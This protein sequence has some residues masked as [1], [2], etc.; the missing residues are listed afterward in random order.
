MHQQR[1]TLK[2]TLVTI[3]L[4]VGLLGLGLVLSTDFA[5]RDLAFH[6]QEEAL[7]KLLAIKSRDLTNELIQRQKEL[8]FVM[9][10]EHRFK[11][12]YAANDI[13]ELHYWLDQEFNRYFSTMGLIKLE[14]LIIYD[15]NFNIITKSARGI[16][17]GDGDAT[18]CGSLIN[19]ISRLSIIERLKPRSELCLYD[20]KPLLSTVV[21]IGSLRSKGF[22]QIISNPAYILVDIEKELDIQLQITTAENRILHQSSEWPLNTVSTSSYLFS[23]YAI[24]TTDGTQVMNIKGCNKY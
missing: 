21:S 16:A 20:G 2:F 7:E 8:G 11:K 17:M 14:K 23:N 22:I 12:A 1:L 5:Y 19:Y 6:Q 9:Q 18:P 4:L 24:Q 15:N 10:S 3:V 13:K